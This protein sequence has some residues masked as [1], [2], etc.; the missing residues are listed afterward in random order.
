MEPILVASYRCSYANYSRVD[1]CVNVILK[2]KQNIHK[3]HNMK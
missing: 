1:S 2:N 3:V